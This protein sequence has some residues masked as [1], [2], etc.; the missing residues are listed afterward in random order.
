MKEV[1]ILTP[2]KSEARQDGRTGIEPLVRT[3]H[4]VLKG[5]DITGRE[6]E[7]KG[8]PSRNMYAI[9]AWL[10]DEQIT[11]VRQDS[12]VFISAK[13]EPAYR[14]SDVDQWLKNRGFTDHPVKQGDSEAV[15]TEK[16]RGYSKNLE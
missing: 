10:T 3:E 2:Y 13:P 8:V 12:R 4:G 15:A 1:I 14:A 9:K 5:E 11:A 7:A 16:L 6:L